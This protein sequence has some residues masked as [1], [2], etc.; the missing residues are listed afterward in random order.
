MI[1]PIDPKPRHTGRSRRLTG[2]ELVLG[3]IVSIAVVAGAARSEP[4]VTGDL[5]AWK[6]VGAAYTRLLALSGYRMRVTIGQAPDMLFEVVPPAS[7]RMI[8]PAG[9]GSMETITVRGQSRFRINA[10]GGPGPWECQGSPS[11]EFP[12]NPA[13]AIQG[14]IEVS[15]GADTAIAGSAVR[16]YAY[17][18]AMTVQGQ[19]VNATTTLYVGGETGLPR[20]EVTMSGGGDVTTDFYDYGAK[21]DIQLPSCPGG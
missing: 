21:I 12:R 17:R 5:A 14:T 13:G 9:N 1:V 4:T 2:A 11:V 16:T 3:P 19:A 15:R 7:V 18:Y 6:E 10:P 20:R 8:V